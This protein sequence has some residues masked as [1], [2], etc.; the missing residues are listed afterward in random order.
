[1]NSKLYTG[2][3]K[4]KY[5]DEFHLHIQYIQV[6]ISNTIASSFDLISF[7][8]FKTEKRGKVGNGEWE[9]EW[10]IMRMYV[11]CQKYFTD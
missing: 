10:G 1:M 2:G 6:N 5:Y 4:K 11:S 3:N 9:R 7:N 8:K